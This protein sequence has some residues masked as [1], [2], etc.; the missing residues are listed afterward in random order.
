MEIELAAVRRWVEDHESRLAL[1][2]NMWPYVCSVV[3]TA[4]GAFSPIATGARNIELAL[5]L[6]PAS[7]VL[8]APD[9]L[10]VLHSVD[11]VL[12]AMRHVARAPDFVVLSGASQDDS[13]GTNAEE[14]R[15]LGIA[16]PV[17]VL[18]P[19]HDDAAPLAEA[20][21]TSFAVRT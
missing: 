3:E 6:E 18:G 4:G 15:A 1:S 21:L 7:F 12:T 16:D 10:G 13:T 19:G 17:L 5:A 8:V 20:L 11:S 14:L 9:A 2:D